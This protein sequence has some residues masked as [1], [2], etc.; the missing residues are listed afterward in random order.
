MLKFPAP[1]A[2]DK[3]ELREGER[4]GAEAGGVI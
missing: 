4:D 2:L 1:G 3:P